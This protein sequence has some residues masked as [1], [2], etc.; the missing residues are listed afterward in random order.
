MSRIGRKPI[1]IPAG[2]EVKIDGQKISVKG[3]KGELQREIC[4]EIKAEVKEG[5]VTIAPQAETKRTKALWGLTRALVF[6]MVKGVTEGYEKKLQVEGVGYK[7]NIEGDNLV[8]KLGFSHLVKVGQ[9][10]GIKFTVEKNVI[11]VAGFDKELVGQL[12]A[13][14]RK[15]CPPEPY[16]GTGI[17]YFGEIIKR[18]AG[19]KVVTAGG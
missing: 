1:L 10:A 17:K 7:A 3:P 16:K 15:V 12:A 8:L 2:V 11:S 6:N 19:K 14:I 5:S 9:P 13:K 4:P 18:K